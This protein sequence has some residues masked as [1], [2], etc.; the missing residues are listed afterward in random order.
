M[1]KNKI[2]EGNAFAINIRQAVWRTLGGVIQPLLASELVDV[3]LY[4]GSGTSK[5]TATEYMVTADGDTISAV[6][7]A[8]LKR[9]VYRT[10][11]TAIYNGREVASNC[12]AAFEI[13]AFDEH[14]QAYAPEMVDAP[15]AV[16]LQPADVT[17][18]ELEQ[19]KEEFR[20]KNAALDA[21]KAEAEQARQEYINKAEELESVA[22][23]EQV[24]AVAGVLVGV[25][26]SIEDVATKQSVDD[27]NA[28]LGTITAIDS[29]IRAGKQAI[30][31]NINDKGVVSS[32]NDT[33][34][35][36]ASK[37]KQI[38]QT[39]VEMSGSETYELQTYGCVTDMEMPYVQSGSTWNLYKIMVDLLNDGRFL[40]HKGI[41]LAEYPFE[42]ATITLYGVGASG[43]YLTSD[44]HLYS[45]D[46]VH[47]WEDNKTNRWV[48][49]IYK[50]ASKFNVLTYN[51][52]P[53]EIHIGRNVGEVYFQDNIRTRL[54]RIVVTD[55]NTL[56]RFY[57]RSTQGYIAENVFRNISSIYTY[58]QLMQDNLIYDVDKVESTIGGKKEQIQPSSV[59][60][61]KLVTL[62]SGQE[63][64]MSYKR[65]F[66]ANKYMRSVRFAK[67]QVATFNMIIS[68][69]QT[70]T[71]VQNTGELHVYGL[72]GIAS[73]YYL[74]NK[75]YDG[76]SLCTPVA[77][78]CY[79]LE[80]GN[81]YSSYGDAAF[82][83]AKIFIPKYKGGKVA[84]CQL[85]GLVDC[86][87]G[88]C[89]SNLDMSAWT[90]A[91]LI[92]DAENVTKI[93]ANI[94]D[95]IAA[96]VQDR[97]GLD[98]LT[99][100]VGAALFAVLEEETLN[101]FSNKNWNVAGV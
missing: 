81:L 72:V 20:A 15:M 37:I 78:Y 4:V 86:V 83:L 41:V 11:I 26:K 17:D 51:E 36:M 66:I 27:V 88:E 14:Y 84:D 91:N 47:T 96:N 39:K 71:Q 77:I 48:A 6:M 89:D 25:A 2:T 46:V 38:A 64:L 63:G 44:G 24:D 40:E 33:L 23:S 5:S 53:T 7:P 67:G 34:V 29:D 68:D 45:E 74:I 99:F 54:K 82:N 65:D 85:T 9:G 21:A 73:R 59:E 56:G 55:G 75:T 50:N 43:L 35:V 76:K 31:E 42:A 80:Y 58:Y 12:D 69:T 101:A 18:A 10:W 100:S 8:T 70:S 3:H 90:A 49:Y 87:V 97:N 79:D 98:A 13:V 61:K 57:I 94:R 95:H 16:Y 93:N 19:L 30:S 92:G 22:T 1:T 28:T 52:C 62:A 60:F 32:P